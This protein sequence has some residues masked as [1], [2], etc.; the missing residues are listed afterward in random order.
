M[1]GKVSPV[2]I[3]VKAPSDQVEKVDVNLRCTK[4]QLI[5]PCSCSSNARRISEVQLLNYELSEK[6]E[7]AAET[8][9]GMQTRRRKSV[10]TG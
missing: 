10:S 1:N 8:V 6:Q 2:S 9:R 3:P 5:M 7:L 4:C